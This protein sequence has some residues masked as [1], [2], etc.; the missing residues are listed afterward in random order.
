MNAT[1]RGEPG[2]GLPPSSSVPAAGLLPS[3]ALAAFLPIFATLIVAAALPGVQAEFG[4]AGSTSGFLL[5]V[6]LLGLAIGYLAGGIASDRWGRRAVLLTALGLFAMASLLISVVQSFAPFLVLRI[7]Q[8][9]FGGAALIV[10]S[11]IVHD[12]FAGNV[13]RAARGNVA[14]ATATALGPLLGIP[15]GALLQHTASWRLGFVLVAA[16]G[17]A[18]IAAG[19]WCV[20]HRRPRP[21]VGHATHAAALPTWRMHLGNGRLLAAALPGALSLS[22]VYAFMTAA[23]FLVMS[24]WGHEPG[25]FGLA[26]MLPPAGMLVA[27]LVTRRIISRRF[28]LFGR[29]ARIAG[30]LQV[31]G[32]LLLAL[33]LSGGWLAPASLFATGVLWAAGNGVLIGFSVTFALSQ[34]REGLGTAGAL[35]GFLH[36]T[37]A[38]LGSSF[39]SLADGATAG[40]LLAW[41]A[42]AACLNVAAIHLAARHRAGAAPEA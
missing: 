14:I 27:G 4:L 10:L 32:A 25:F 1:D 24:D 16:L 15:A 38:A 13:P 28:A 34:A 2:L 19:S 37:G 20:P 35:V 21:R 33:A 18:A 7:A 30:A 26:S 39:I 42:A 41:S 12:V 29:L 11:P 17:L 3:L 6:N 9:L 40:H 23:P 8:A 22:I 5:A 31:A 36:M